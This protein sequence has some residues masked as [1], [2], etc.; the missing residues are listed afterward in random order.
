MIDEIKKMIDNSKDNPEELAVAMANLFESQTKGLK[1]NKDAIL[2]EK[3]ANEEK[4][5]KLQE[6]IDKIDIEEYNSLKSDKQRAELIGKGSSSELADI[7]LELERLQTDNQLINQQLAEAKDS[8]S[9]LENNI[10][11]DK[12]KIALTSGYQK[13][14]VKPEFIDLLVKANK[15]IA[16]AQ[17]G[18]DGSITVL[19]PTSDGGI[20]PAPQF[21]EAWKNSDT[22][23][24]FIQ[25]PSNQGGGANGSGGVNGHKSKKDMT[26]AEANAYALQ[27]GAEAYKQLS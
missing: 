11:S 3:K 24:S 23:K 22:A 13:A 10:K 9:T 26:P 20:V 27:H 21:F 16:K 4:M 18:E 15:D 12:I 25:A 14:G 5:K 6:T 17:T 8:K 7:Q 1:E 19:M 2:L